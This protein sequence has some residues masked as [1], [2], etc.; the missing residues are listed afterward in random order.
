MGA[1]A[2][3]PSSSTLT[4]EQIGDLV[5][6]CGD[7]YVTYRSSFIRAGIDGQFLFRI[8]D[9]N[10]HKHLS[11]LG[12]RND[13][14][15]NTLSHRLL[16]A[17][18][19]VDMDD[20]KQTTGSDF[21][22]R[23]ITIALFRA[24]VKEALERNPDKTYW[25]MGRVSAELIGNHEI[26][27]PDCRFGFVDKDATLT[28]AADSSLIEMLKTAYHEIPHVK[29]GVTYHQAVGTRANM[30]VSFAYGDN[31]ID[32]V[33][34]LELF[35]QDEKRDPSMT[36]FWFDMFVNDQW[37]A[38]DHDFDWW[39][40][41]FSTAVESIGETVIFLSPWDQPG[42]LKRAWCLFEISCSKK[43]SV[44]ISRAQKDAFVMTLREDVGEIY[45]ALCTIDLEKATSYLPED[46]E[47]ISTVVRAKEGGFHHFNV[48]VVGKMRGWVEETARAL[49]MEM[50][51]EDD[52]LD[53]LFN[54]ANLLAKG[55]KYDEAQAMY[56]RALRGY[57]KS[58]GPDHTK[59]RNTVHNIAVLL[60]TQGKYDE[61]DAMY[62]RAL[63]GKEKALG[64]DHPDTLA[65]V[66]N[67]GALLYEHGE[68]DT[69]QAMYD[70]ALRGQEKSLGPDH[71]DT[72]MTV[73]NLGFLL[74]QQGK[75]DEAKVIYERALQACEMVL[76]PDHK[77]I[78]ELTEC[79]E[80]F[81]PLQVAIFSPSAVA[82]KHHRNVTSGRIF[83][84]YRVRFRNFN[85]VIGDVHLVG[86]KFYYEVEVLTMGGSPQFGWATEGFDRIEANSGGG[87]GDDTYSWGFDGHRI[88]KWNGG[89]QPFGTGWV[90]G[91]VLGLA[92]DLVDKTVSFSVNGNFSEPCGVAFTN[93]D[94]PA[95][96]IM[97]ALT[98]HSGTYQI[99]FGDRSFIHAPPD[100]SYQSVA[101]GIQQ[102]K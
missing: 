43:V 70:R 55:G 21:E 93:I 57:E 66:N 54:A 61:A 62:V 30:F 20:S 86:G 89:S 78:R 50:G 10:I 36:Y 95:S 64:P 2:S 24:I 65:M 101:L 42:M 76:G 92:I 98:S 9:Q 97:P 44:A 49:V 39:A 7:D 51:V 11:E 90:A 6:D 99:N 22:L 79:L 72:L 35:L 84:D 25:N 4:I 13:E 37:H 67:L 48:T 53:D 102:H 3:V 28:Y 77:T 91:D 83:S 16:Q 74:Y 38:L 60:K 81:G 71:T 14:R 15:I 75:L 34:G 69:A 12:I 52:Q 100:V 19:Y 41:T 80:D 56:D 23:G 63:R 31:F 27:K 45:K 85:T 73:N 94:I 58:L 1:G 82:L 32:L 29:L 40:N 33:E 26:L 68:N 46:M 88:M 5:A 8:D 59:T 47:R 96:W 18:K 17:K 87:V